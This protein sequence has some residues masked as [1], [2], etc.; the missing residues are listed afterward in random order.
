MDKEV[1]PHFEDYIFDWD[2][3]TYFIVGGY[4]SSK[5]YS[6]ALKIILKLLQERRTCLVVREVF[7]TIRDSCLSLFAEIIEELNLEKVIKVTQ[8]PMQVRFKNGSKIIFKGMDKP[9]KLKSIN[10]VSLL[11]IEEAPEVK[12]A[13]YKELIGRLR[14]PILKLHVI[15]TSNPIEFNSWTY[16]HFFKDK[17]TGRVVLEDREL[18]EKRTVIINKTYYHHST[19]DDN[20]FLPDSY[21]EK[22]DD[23][24]NYD[25]DMYRIARLGHFGSNG[26][27]VMP[28]F[29]VMNHQTVMEKVNRLHLRFVGMDFG[30]VESYNAV[31]RYAVDDNAT[32]QILYIYWEYYKRDMTDD[33]TAEELKEFVITGE[34][35]TA[36]SAE[37]KTIRYYKEMG[38]RMYGAKKGPGSRLQNI[39]KFKRFKKIICSDECKNHIQEWKE[40]TF[41]KDKNDNIIEDEFNIDPHTFSA[42]WYGL[43]GY[44]VSDL[45]GGYSVSK[46]GGL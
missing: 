30:F 45:K 17:D 1:N 6:T 14:H 4:G 32:G 2:Y 44:E 34:R 33:K 12:Y 36:D 3:E 42:A 7:E 28:Q 31:G 26:I 39:K 35:I 38:F 23:M 5:S 37:P 29:E 16:R 46:P 10:N 13:G 40:L 25:P 22:L 15:L 18:Y 27:K 8:S 24:M 41:A 19:C 21:I 9:Q 43:E 20:L 11:W